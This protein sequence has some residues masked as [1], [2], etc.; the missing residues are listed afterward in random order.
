MIEGKHI[1]EVWDYRLSIAVPIIYREGKTWVVAVCSK[2]SPDYTEGGTP[3]EPL[4]I[5]DTGIPSEK[6]DAYDTTKVKVCYEWLL[7]V[8]DK[9]SLSNIEELK[10][11]AAAA[12]KANAELAEM[13]KNLTPAQARL[14]M[15]ELEVWLEALFAEKGVIV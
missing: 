12:N 7:T 2:V 11:L 15:A 8:R 4:E 3:A 10:P 6:G 14:K 9:Y 13:C 5:H 1:L